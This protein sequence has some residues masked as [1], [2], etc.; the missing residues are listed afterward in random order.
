MATFSELLRTYTERTGISDS[1]LARSIG[2]RR[3]T[4]FRW[5]EGTVARPRNRDDVIRCA[6]RLRLTPDELDE[7]LLAAGMAPERIEQATPPE[8]D[9]T[10][11]ENVVADEVSP[12][13]EAVPSVAEVTIE[14]AGERPIAGAPPTVPLAA[15]TTA[16]IHL[17]END[18]AVPIDTPLTAATT[19][20]AVTKNVPSRR[21][22]WQWTALAAVP[23]IAII[24][25]FLMTRG[26][27][28]PR[29]TP[30]PNVTATRVVVVPDTPPTPT[31]VPTAT[32]LPI[33]PRGETWLLVARF[34]NYTRDEGF[35]VARRIQRELKS[36]IGEIELPDTYVDTLDLVV[37]DA[38]QARQVL[39][40]T[41]ATLLIWGW[42][43]SGAV[44]VELTDDN[45]LTLSEWE[46]QL[47]S[48][49]E[50]AP[51]I[52]ADI[53]K[54]VSVLVLY[55]LG[56]LYE[57]EKK[58]KQARLVLEEAL[59]QDPPNQILG[60]I[61]FNL[62]S[63]YL[64]GAP[65]NVERSIEYSSKAVTHLISDVDVAKAN[66]N[67][68]L[69]FWHRYRIDG[70]VAD[71]EQT[72]DEISKTL[73]KLPR[74]AK[75]YTNRGIAYYSRNQAGDIDNAIRDYTR[76]INLYTSAVNLPSDAALLAY[77]NR[78]LARLRLNADG[79]VE[80]WE[81]AIELN[82]DDV[83]PYTGL[84]WGYALSPTPEN[85][86][87]YCTQALTMEPDKGD[88]YDSRGIVYARLGR[89]AEAIAEFHEY[90]K[91]L[92]L[93]PAAYYERYN[94]PLIE[95]W[96]DAL[97]VDEMPFTDEVLDELR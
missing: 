93:Q 50:L 39:M 2:V 52:N 55:I 58:Y 46:R 24:G 45:S 94:G 87:E 8:V 35:N 42:F 83:R 23:I 10:I 21:L 85:A 63:Y 34:G 73:S 16:T 72:I 31:P 95:E 37:E 38:E 76:A 48:P 22:S 20:T 67:R 66:Y 51:T 69:A 89:T 96:I 27:S 91:W 41:G 70:D 84:C 4:I 77:Y 65:I 5:K 75:A 78:G 90:L 62:G 71:L 92:R 49:A 25:I 18:V 40:D 33:M 61:Y 30:T 9:D 11:V 97:E 43:D 60:S 57:D 44:R 82:S 81:T 13:E 14:T 6:K 36:Q 12:A 17:G 47:N 32:A 26:G 1:E 88:V 19:E 86:L 80:D 54:E 59:A 3:Q 68:G 53:P 15:S 28:A 64:L 29:P 7:F 74:F 56:K 79:W